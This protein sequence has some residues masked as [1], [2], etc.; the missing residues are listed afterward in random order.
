MKPIWIGAMIMTMTTTAFMTF[1]GLTSAQATP[2]GEAQDKAAIKTIVESVATLADRQNFDV[3][4]KLYADEIAVDY[5]SLTGGDP[6]VKSPQGL[7]SEWA[8]SLPGFDRTRHEISNVV[9]E[10][11]GLKAVA[12]ADVTADHYIGGLFW[13]VS[14][15]YRYALAKQGSVWLITAHTFTVEGEDGTRNVFGPAAERAAA[16]PPAYVMRKQ[17]KKAVVSFLSALETKD[18]EKFADVWA[19]DAVQDMPFSPEG[20]PKRVS[21]KANLIAHYAGWPENAGEADFTSALVFYPM[22]DP[23]M[24]FAEF[25]GRTQIIPTGRVYDQTYGGLFHVE[26]GKIKLFREF[27]D[28]AAFKYAF[29]LDEG[30]SFHKKD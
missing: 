19:E 26:D 7:M 6:Q 2:T 5:T 13:Q 8:A 16:N 21:G 24:V 28:P 9:V 1:S 20:F 10:V 29:G 4:E 17:T 14:G 11:M 22:Q 18:M 15:N 12:T 25:K 27:Y 3:L 23:Q 30:G